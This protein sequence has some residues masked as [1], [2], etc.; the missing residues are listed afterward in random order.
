MYR[1]TFNNLFFASTENVDHLLLNLFLSPTKK[2][3]RFTREYNL[4]KGMRQLR[5]GGCVK[6]FTKMPVRPLL[7]T[8]GVLFSGPLHFLQV[9]NNCC[10]WI[11]THDTKKFVAQ[12]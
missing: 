3:T 11:I 7:L 1:Y 10:S 4:T 12:N 2:W 9:E 8:A 6:G 5:E